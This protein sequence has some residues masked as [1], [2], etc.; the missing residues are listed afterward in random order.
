MDIYRA[1]C[2]P[3]YIAYIGHPSVWIQTRL[4]S[5]FSIT[6]IQSHFCQVKIMWIDW[7]WGKSS[8]ICIL[9][10]YASFFI[11]FL[12]SKRIFFNQRLSKIQFSSKWNI[13]DM[14]MFLCKIASVVVLHWRLRGGTCMSFLSHYMIILQHV[15]QSVHFFKH[16]LQYYGL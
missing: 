9:S 15:S 6:V 14:F 12:Y 5:K 7:K 3:L 11:F 16:R 2:K 8:L 1:I 4:K 10:S 13:F